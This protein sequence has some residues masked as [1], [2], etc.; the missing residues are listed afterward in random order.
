MWIVPVRE[1]I[2]G[3]V[4]SDHRFRFCY[5]VEVSGL[6]LWGLGSGSVQ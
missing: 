4:F 3:V 2:I 5:W 1:G 6:V